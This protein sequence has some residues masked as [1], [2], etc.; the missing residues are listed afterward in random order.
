MTFRGAALLTLVTCLLAVTAAVLGRRAEAPSDPRIVATA[1]DPLDDPRLA[2]YRALREARTAVDL[3][4][5]EELAFGSE[6]YSAYLAALELARVDTAPAGV[7]ARALERALELRV[8]DPLRRAEERALRLELGE[9]WEEAGDAPAA[10]AAYTAALPMGRAIAGAERTAPDRYRLAAAFQRAGMHTRALETLGELAAPSIE[11]PSLRAL[12]RY[13]EALAAYRRW[14]AE[15]PGDPDALSGEAWCLYYLGRDAEAAATFEALGGATGSYGLGLLAN[16]AGDATRAVELMVASGRA[17]V[18]WLA[19]GIL[20]A[21][22]RYAEAIPVYLTLA[23]GGSAYADDAAFRAYVLAGRL[24]DEAARARAREL[25]P[26]GSFFALV[27]GDPPAVPDPSVE[28]AQAG[29]AGPVGALPGDEMA[30]AEE[31]SAAAEALE[32]AFALMAV[33]D[34]DA[35]VGELLFALRDAESAGDVA[36]VL[37]VAEALQSMDEYRQSGRAGRE[38]LAAGVQDLRAWRLAYPP[39]WPETVLAAAAEAG[40]EPALIWAVMRQESAFSE[41]AVSVANAQG[42]MQVIPSTWDWIAEMRKEAPRDPFDVEA[43][44]WYGATYLGWLMDYWDG[45]VE[46]VIASYNGGQ[47]Y[48]RRVFNADYVAGDKWEF[49]REIDRS[50]TREYLQLVYENLAVYRTLYPALASG[51]LADQGH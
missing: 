24:G 3:T 18:L 11:A 19:T 9:L 41:V 50:E 32:L 49:Y 30:V 17:D 47:G 37:D 40:V 43:N 2:P 12:G 38:L 13:E 15:V 10:F 26:H 46:L 36:A 34:R 8:H 33:N 5:L 28:A 21:R 7:R 22:D 29:G 27:L 16:R 51:A 45:D 1:L 6:A 31:P 4:R 23:A 42:L 44:I 48:V 14:L 39:A 20:E 35:A 25:M